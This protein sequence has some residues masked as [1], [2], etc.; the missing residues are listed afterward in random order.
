MKLAPGVYVSEQICKTRGK[1][2]QYSYVLLAASLTFLVYVGYHMCRVPIGIIE[3]EE[4]FLNCTEAESDDESVCSSWILEMDNITKT[5]ARKKMANMKTI[6]GF[7]YAFCMFPSGYLGDHM[8]LRHFLSGSTLLYAVT[9]YLFG[10]GQSWGIRSIWYYY[11][12]MALQ[13]RILWVRV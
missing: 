11:V 2:R 3:S 12:I 7:A 8:D 1:T 4:S 13:V 5:S 10:A 6:W 9:I